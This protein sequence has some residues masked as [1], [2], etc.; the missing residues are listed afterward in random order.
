MNYFVR[1]GVSMIG[2]E[3]YNVQTIGNDIY[4]IGE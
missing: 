4:V 1:K 3:I 2:E